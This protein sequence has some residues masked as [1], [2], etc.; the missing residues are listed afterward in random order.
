MLNIIPFVIRNNIKSMSLWLCEQLGLMVREPY[1]FTYR[2]VFEDN[3]MYGYPPERVLRM[4]TDE[5]ADSADEG[6][7][8]HY[9]RTRWKPWLAPYIFGL[10]PMKPNVTYDAA[11]GAEFSFNL[12]PHSTQFYRHDLTTL[13]DFSTAEISINESSVIEALE[14]C[15]GTV[16]IALIAVINPVKTSRNKAMITF[17][18]CDPKDAIVFKMRMS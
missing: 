5:I 10:T 18:F 14:T 3:R 15:K 13:A 6:F 16:Q 4:S 2:E 9:F 1:F 11:K 7:R 17:W 12:Q 8:T